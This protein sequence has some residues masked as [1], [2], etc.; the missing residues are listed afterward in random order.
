MINKARKQNVKAHLDDEDFNNSRQDKG[1][2]SLLFISS[3]NQYRDLHI[4]P[5]CVH[6]SAKNKIL[7]SFV[8]VSSHH[9]QIRIEGFYFFNNTD[10]RT[11]ISYRNRIF[12]PHPCQA[13]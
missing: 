7:N 12:V 9:Q 10:G 4:M 2:S 1:T 8:S 11:T 13:F 3:H 6:R 5:N